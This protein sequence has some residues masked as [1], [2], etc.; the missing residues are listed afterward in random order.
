[1]VLINAIA[2]MLVIVG[3]TL[4]LQLWRQP[5]MT[6]LLVITKLF[7]PTKGGAALSFDD[8]LR[9]LGRREIHI[10]TTDVPGARELD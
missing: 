3:G 9:H 5:P 6:Q 8:D 4:L 7:L 10:V 2:V 1:M